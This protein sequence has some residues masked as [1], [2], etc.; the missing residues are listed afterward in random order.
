MFRHYPG[1][2]IVNNHHFIDQLLPLRGK[3]TNGGRS[4]ANPHTVFSDPI[5]NWWLTRLNQQLQPL[6][7]LHVNGI[8]IT[9]AQQCRTSH[10]AFLFA[11]TCQMIHPTKRKHLRSIFTCCD[12]SNRLAINAYQTTFWPNMAVGINFYLGAAIAKDALGHN[13]HHVDAIMLAGNYKRSRFVIWI[14]R[15]STNRRHKMVIWRNNAAV[16]WF[17]SI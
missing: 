1:D 8:T 3:H 12:M 7:N 5:N 11:A 14:G 13:G 9:Q 6:I 15:T 17:V 4:T 10:P 2:M 16:P